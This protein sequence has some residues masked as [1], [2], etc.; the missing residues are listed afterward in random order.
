MKQQNIFELSKPGR[1][2]V[3]PPK[4]GVG[5]TPLDQLI[6]SAY[7]RETPAKLPE[8]AEPQVVRHYIRLSTMNHHIDKAMYPLGSCTM[9]YNPKINDRVATL[10]GFAGLHPEMPEHL[11]QGALQLMH[12]L[13]QMLAV[14]A[15]MDEVSVQPVAGAQGEMVGLLLMRAFHKNHG[16]NRKKIIIPDSAHGTNPASVTLTGFEPVALSSGKDGLVDVEDLASVLD[17]HTAGLM[18]TN[19][20]TLGLFEKNIEQINAMVHE[21]GGLIYMDGANLNAMLGIVRP[22]DMGFDIVHFNLHKTFSTPHGGGGPGAGAV[23]V[24]DHLTRF[25]PGPRI[26]KDQ[27]D[28]APYFRHEDVGADSIGRLHS[29]DGNFGI[30][31]RAYAYIKRLGRE[32]LRQVAEDAILNANYLAARVKDYYELPHPLPCQHEFV[33]SASRQKKQRVRAGAIAKR[34]LDF[35]VHSPTV[36]FPLIVPEALMIEPTETESKESLD[37]F[38]EI[39]IQ[40]AKEVETDADLVNSAPHNTPLRKLNEAKAAKE[41]DVCWPDE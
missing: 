30:M 17:D 39:M 31:V 12:E 37:N 10:P 9:K 5:D 11:C 29:F 16:N 26:V 15:G 8:V 24:K 40:I 34:L 33:L 25:L 38:A 13:S 14:I 32:G 3:T 22:G 35:G 20:N 18:L 41:L 28:G 7:R 21:A 23:G 2:G 36:Y 1:Q 19:P 27:R 4:P 6:P